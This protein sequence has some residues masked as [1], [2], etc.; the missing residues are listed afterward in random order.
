MINNIVVNQNYIE[1]APFGSLLPNGVS[2]NSFIHI[3]GD[4]DVGKTSL[5]LEIAFKNRDK[6]FVFIDT[7]NSLS[8]LSKVPDNVFIISTND[9]DEIIMLLEDT[10][11]DCFDGVI[12]D[13]INNLTS[14]Q[15]KKRLSEIETGIYRLLSY[16]SGHNKILIAINGIL[17][18]GK[19]YCFSRRISL[20]C[21]LNINIVSSKL[22]KDMTINMLLKAKKNRYGGLRQLPVLIE[23]K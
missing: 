19:P 9:I 2:P 5:A 4:N 10:P 11:L 12:L 3:Y 8:S 1:M 16:T 18:D 23:R 17:M 20:L 6:I 15:E 22:N 13:S 14:K 21:G 7:Y